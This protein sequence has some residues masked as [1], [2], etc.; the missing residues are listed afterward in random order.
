MTWKELEGKRKE[1]WR[2]LSE[3]NKR[4]RENGDNNQIILICQTIRICQL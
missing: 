4:S 3:E 1:T 2:K